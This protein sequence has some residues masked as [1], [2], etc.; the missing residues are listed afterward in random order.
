MSWSGEGLR[1]YQQQADAYLSQANPVSTT[2]YTVLDTTL[3]VRLTSCTATVTWG[4]TQPTPLEIVLT[5]DGQTITHIQANPVS[6]QAYEL[7]QYSDTAANN[8]GMIATGNIRKMSAPFSYEGRSV[9]VQVRVTWAVTQ[10][11]PL[12]CRVKYAKR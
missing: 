1:Q 7:S 6:V 10:P 3:N 8:Q 11:T 4:V 2:L 5:I 9:K 12:E